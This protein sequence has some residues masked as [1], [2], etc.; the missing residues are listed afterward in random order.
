MDITSYYFMTCYYISSLHNL[1]KYEY[2]HLSCHHL[3]Q[4]WYTW[5][6]YK[7]DQLTYGSGGNIRI[8]ICVR[9]YSGI[10]YC[11]LY[12]VWPVVLQGTEGRAGSLIHVMTRAYNKTLLFS[13]AAGFR[14][15]ATEQSWTVIPGMYGVHCK[16]SS[17]IQPFVSNNNLDL[18]IYGCMWVG[19]SPSHI[20]RYMGKTS[21]NKVS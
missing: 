8:S 18:L 4:A 12:P 6:S 15:H 11:A 10:R 7:M 13:L 20:P 16:H 21:N 14:F 9:V 2:H 3:N 19:R 1:L 5:L 17:L